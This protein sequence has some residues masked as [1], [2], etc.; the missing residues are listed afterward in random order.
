MLQ[1][2]GTWYLRVIIPM[3][4]KPAKLPKICS[5]DAIPAS[6]T[7]TTTTTTTQGLMPVK[8]RFELPTCSQ[9]QPNDQGK[10]RGGIMRRSA[11]QNT[12]PKKEKNPKPKP[13]KQKKPQRPKKP[14]TKT[15]AAKPTPPAATAPTTSRAN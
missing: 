9:D 6:T 8:L 12:R 3:M 1:V 7:T 11:L 5:R 15:K 14:V 13:H 10:N 2:Y 4:H